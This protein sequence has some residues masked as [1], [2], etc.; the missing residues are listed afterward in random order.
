M[1]R[2]ARAGVLIK[3]GA[4]LENLGSLNAIAFD[5]TGTLTEGR[6]RITDIVPVGGA[7]ETDLL[8]TA[9]AVERLHRERR[10]PLARAGALA[11]HQPQAFLD[12]RFQRRVLAPRHRLAAFEQIV[13]QFDGGL[14]M[15]HPYQ[16]YGRHGKR[17]VS[18]DQGAAGPRPAVR[19]R[20]I[21]SI[22]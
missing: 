14:Q 7:S 16:R 10:G 15:G 1:A 3:G 8:M 5:K 13:G 4:P 19:R 6:P 11:Q 12:Q 17:G 9:V 18:V 22:T 21:G 20:R 2:A